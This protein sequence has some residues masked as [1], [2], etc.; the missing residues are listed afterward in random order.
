LWEIIQDH[1][2]NNICQ[3]GIGEVAHFLKFYHRNK[4][5]KGMTTNNIINKRQRK[6]REFILQ[7]KK[8]DTIK[9]N[10]ETIIQI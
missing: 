8:E 5:D 3:I 2:L 4:C 10:L 7:G 6:R 9:V 1:D